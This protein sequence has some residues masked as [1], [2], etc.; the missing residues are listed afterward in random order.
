M[1]VFS[2][3]FA[4]RRWRDLPVSLRFFRRYYF[5]ILAIQHL[6]AGVSKLVCHTGRIADSRQTVA[7]ETVP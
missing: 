3:F 2:R 1:V 7:G 5:A 4:F 6:R